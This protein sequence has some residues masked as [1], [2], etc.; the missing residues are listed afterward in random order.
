M[1]KNTTEA[2]VIV[3]LNG[4]TARNELKRLEDEIKQYEQAAADAY[5]AGDKALGDKMSKNAQNL[6]KEF[7]VAK[8]EMKDFSDVIKNLNTKTLNELESAAKQLH[9]QLKGLSPASQEYIEKSK[10]LQQVNQRINDLRKSFKAVTVETEKSK[11]SLRNLVATYNH[12]WGAIT[13]TITAMTSMSL[14]FRQ[15][16]EEAAKLDDVYSDVMKTTG[17]LH[18][19]VEALDKELMKIDTR[20]S[21]EQL[22]L[23]ARDAGKLGISGQEDILG[24]VRAA[25]KIQVALGEDLG[26]GAIKNLGKIADVFGLT[27][28]MGIEKS[29]LSIASAVNA[30]GQDSTAAEAYLVDF[31]QRLAGVGAMAGLSVQDILGFASGLDQSAMKV[32][33]AA[34]AFQKFLMKM[35]EDTATFAGYAG[36][37]VEE[38]SELLKNDA[39]T[40]I[41]TVMKAMNGQDGFASLVPMFDQMG[42]D[43]ARAVTVLASMTQNLEAVTEAQ[44]LANEEFA[45]ATSI[46]EEYATKNNNHQALLEKKRKEFQ[47]AAVTLGQKLNPVLLKSTSAT[48]YLIKALVLYGKEIKAVMIAIAALTLVVKA[49]AI[50]EGIRSAALKIGNTLNKTGVVTSNYLKLGYYRL[51]GQTMKAAAAQTALNTAM[52]ASVF[53]VIAIAVGLLVGSLVH[54]IRKNREAAESTEDLT[55]KETWEMEISKKIASAKSEEAGKI[56]ALNKILHDENIAYGE[57]LKALNELKKIV[58]DYHASLTKEG[59]LINDNI[60]AVENYVEAL[61]REAVVKKLGDEFGEIEARKIELESMI[62]DLQESIEGEEWINEEEWKVNSKVAK[63]NIEIMKLG[64]E[65]DEV[66][67]KSEKLEGMIA[68]AVAT[69]LG[70][71]TGGKGGGGGGSNKTDINKQ[72]FQ[73]ALQEAEIRQRAEENALK[74]RYLNEKM[75][76]EK[77]EEEL[78]DIKYKYLE[79]KLNLAKEFSQDETGYLSSMLDWEIEAQKR[80]DDEISRLLSERDRWMEEGEND[81]RE[82]LKKLMEEGEKVKASLLSPS[83]ARQNELAAELAR[84]DELHKAKILSE[85]EYE[86]AVKRLRKKYADEDLQEKLSGVAA[87]L[88]QVNTVMSEASNF[89]ASLQSADLARAEAT[90]QAEI[91]AAGNSAEKKEEIEIA[92]EKRKLDI[93]K[94]YADAEMAINIAKTIAD[95]A[96]AIARAFADMPYP[97]ALVVSALIAGTTAA[98]VATIIAQRNAIKSSSVNTSSSKYNSD[99]AATDN[100]KIGSRVITGYAK[101]GYTEG[102]P[103]LTTVGEQGM[104]WIAPHWM[105]SRNPV[106]F[107]SLE[108]YRRS[109]SSGRSGSIERGFADG[110]F[111]PSNPTGGMVYDKE[112]LDLLKEVKQSNEQLN[113]QLAQGIHADVALSE[114][115]RK[116]KLLNKFKQKTSAL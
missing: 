98:Q 53:G 23:L 69:D 35:Y 89:V 51:T 73:K 116:Q 44:S 60:T 96:L 95:G 54:L 74:Q 24:F 107:A 50:A 99:T 29:L 110:G 59:T 9:K 28:S 94:K 20:T 67:K 63:T 46:D 92:F 12:Y 21:R 83:E 87:Y 86:E 81:Y 65:L 31:T 1:G 22:L 79:E 32:E 42:L 39:N 113:H 30:L 48:T 106:M 58:P 47:A 15:C 66:A 25:D 112:L 111:A 16:A 97:A 108:R 7:N 88:Q 45:K 77:Y 64:M 104:E 6:R 71:G 80:V 10:Q 3:T 43:G 76:T 75:A 38:F 90:Y 19:E 17:L 2:E 13:M 62:A 26:E 27:Q 40:A 55:E 61:K 115:N 93:Q 85:Q 11:L 56:V 57:R 33:M 37:K 4:E 114:I 101:G 72:L 18:E 82:R 8:K 70:S 109:G 52:S 41:T 105:V 84:L 36:M 100:G 103:T 5:K 49:N 78:R 91:T 68:K 14:K 102:H 34:T